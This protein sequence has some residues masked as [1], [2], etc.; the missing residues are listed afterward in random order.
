MSKII[1]IHKLLKFQYNVND[2]KRH[3]Q[4]VVNSNLLMEK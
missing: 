1:G 4:T 3:Y 2:T